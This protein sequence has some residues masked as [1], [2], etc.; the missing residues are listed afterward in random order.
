MQNEQK[1]LIKKKAIDSFL[2]GNFIIYPYQDFY[3][4]KA[5]W[6]MYVLPEGRNNDHLITK[7]VQLSTL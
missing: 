4:S 6:T 3:T 1:P 2:K 5:Q 7:R